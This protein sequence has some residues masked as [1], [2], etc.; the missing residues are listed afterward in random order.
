M[1]W[2]NSTLINSYNFKFIRILIFTFMLILKL[3]DS[4]KTKSTKPHFITMSCNGLF[5]GTDGSTVATFSS[6]NP[7]S[8]ISSTS[9]S[10][11]TTSLS[12]KS[13]TATAEINVSPTISPP[14]SSSS[15]SL[16]VTA[17]TISSPSFGSNESPSKQGITSSTAQDVNK[18]NMIIICV[19]VIIGGILILA[20]AGVLLF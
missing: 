5:L 3:L 6:S 7:S 8:S 2:T 13:P 17:N 19:V 15:V 20:A 16:P 9:T 10:T 4:V 18:R 11:S 1:Q 12:S 14:S